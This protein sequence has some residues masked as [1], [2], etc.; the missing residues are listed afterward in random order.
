VYVNKVRHTDSVN[1]SSTHNRK[2]SEA[3]QLR[4]EG[5]V[6]AHPLLGSRARLAH[7]QALA[8]LQLLRVLLEWVAK[9]PEGLALRVELDFDLL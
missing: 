5:W 4:P 3:A 7:T 8:L 2:N 1:R 9:G 6:P